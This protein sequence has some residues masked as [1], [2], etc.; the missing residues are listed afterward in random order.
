MLELLKSGKLRDLAA[1][2]L[3]KTPWTRPWNTEEKQGYTW[4]ANTLD[5]IQPSLVI[6]KVSLIYE[7]RWSFVSLYSGLVDIQDGMFPKCV[8]RLLQ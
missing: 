5:F 2:V 7:L 6:H 4:K 1:L 8:K 3:N